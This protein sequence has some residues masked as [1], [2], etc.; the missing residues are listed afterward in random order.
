MWVSLLRFEAAPLLL[1]FILGPLLEENLRRALLLSR[2]DVS[3]FVDRPISM[4]L[5]IIAVSLLAWSLF[6]SFR[7]LLR[8]R[9]L[10]KEQAQAAHM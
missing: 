5:L 3:T 10:A 9:T 6:S 2:G 7:V 4:W 8:Q 1:G